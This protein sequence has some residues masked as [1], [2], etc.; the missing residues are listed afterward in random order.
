MSKTLYQFWRNILLKMKINE[1]ILRPV[2]TEKATNLTKQKTY[3]L[4]VNKKATK[5][6]VKTALEKLYKVTVDEIRITVRKGKKRRVGRK[7]KSKKL[8]DIKIAYVYIKEGTI[9]L[10]PK[11]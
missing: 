6:Q 5:H 7:M 11:T 2:L 9:D 8:P 10:F 4:E 1:V 3:L